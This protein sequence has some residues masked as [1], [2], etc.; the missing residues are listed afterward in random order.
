M[1]E[2]EICGLTDKFKRM[3]E[4]DSARITAPLRKTMFLIIGHKRNTID[5][6][7]RWVDND[8]KPVEFDYVAE[9]CI[10]SGDSVDELLASAAHYKRML[11]MTMA[12]LL[13]KPEPKSEDALDKAAEELFDAYLDVR[14]EQVEA[15]DGWDKLIGHEA[16]SYSKTYY[17]KDNNNLDGPTIS[18]KFETTLSR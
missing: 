9:T 2:V 16:I 5:D 11:R 18:R 1:T 8:G 3:F 7:G 15:V 6:K 4:A 12:D 14:N 17:V 10:A 13:K